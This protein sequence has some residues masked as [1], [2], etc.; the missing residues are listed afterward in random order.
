MQQLSF[1]FLICP[2]LKLRSALLLTEFS[3]D[4]L[5]LED[6]SRIVFDSVLIQHPKEPPLDD[7][8]VGVLSFTTADVIGYYL[9]KLKISQNH[10]VAEDCRDETLSRF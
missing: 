7:V 6:V 10:R 4:H 3:F 2:S 9:L 5:L 1:R 8:Q